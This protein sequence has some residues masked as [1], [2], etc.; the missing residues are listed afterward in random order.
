MIHRVRFELPSSFFRAKSLSRPQTVQ[1][2]VMFDLGTMV[3]MNDIG[4]SVANRVARSYGSSCGLLLELT[5][6]LC[7][8]GLAPSL[9]RTYQ[10]GKRGRGGQD[11]PL[12]DTGPSK[13]GGSD[14]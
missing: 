12:G 6:G 9:R 8:P 5:T 13:R 7:V 4:T 2:G 11:L 3:S 1:P 14:A 10:T